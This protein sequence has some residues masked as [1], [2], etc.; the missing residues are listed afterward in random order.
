[1]RCS[2]CHPTGPAGLAPVMLQARSV[3]TVLAATAGS[4][5]AGCQV[6]RSHAPPLGGFVM[7]GNK[8]KRS[9]RGQRLARDRCW[10]PASTPAGTVTKLLAAPRVSAVEAPLRAG[11]RDKEPWCPHLCFWGRKWERSSSEGV[12][13]DP[14]TRPRGPALPL[15]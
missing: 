9:D 7:R 15:L 14:S 3:P 5:G 12:L 1:M 10:T 11:R 6:A 2:V 4:G 8:A 13:Q